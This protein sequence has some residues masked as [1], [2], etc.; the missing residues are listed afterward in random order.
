MKS[1]HIKINS[2][3]VICACLLFLFTAF[4]DSV[5]NGNT[6]KRTEPRTIRVT[7]SA[8][9]QLPPDEFT[10]SISYREYWHNSNR[11]NKEPIDV[12]E[13]QILKA[14][15][16][17]GIPTKNITVNSE[18]AWK[19][20]WNY[21]HWWYDYNHYLVSKDLNVKLTSSA[22]LNK[23]IQELKANS[24][25]KQGIVNIQIAGSSNHEIQDYR[26]K[27]KESA[28]KAAKD[29]ADYLLAALGESRG[30]VLSINEIKALPSSTNYNGWPWYRQKVQTNSLN[31][32]VS[33]V[34]M[35]QPTSVSSKQGK[36]DLAMKPIKL[37]YEI[38]AVFEIKE[39]DSRN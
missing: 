23:I 10:V 31:N 25:Q 28:I 3:W 2:L 27:V 20:N 13:K 24:I 17:S 5:P 6:P 32:M 38:E 9:I 15:N 39:R 37:R 33:N 19:H 4:R 18:Y 16:S 29:K 22:Q 36:D 34:S 1:I 12:I 7:G 35:T 26:K 30:V 11:K 14:I 21:W 8:D